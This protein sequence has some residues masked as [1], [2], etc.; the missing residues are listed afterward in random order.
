[1][2]SY[3]QTYSINSQ[4]SSACSLNT[5]APS[6]SMEDPTDGIQGEQRTS[7]LLVHSSMLQRF[8]YSSY[9]TLSFYPFH[10]NRSKSDTHH[11]EAHLNRF[12]KHF[13]GFN[14]FQDASYLCPFC[15]LNILL[16]KLRFIFSPFSYNV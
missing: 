15:L 7:P 2:I 10:C 11:L 5:V 4:W 16:P 3:M 14:P 9:F 13:T 8:S 12:F 6:L 1:M